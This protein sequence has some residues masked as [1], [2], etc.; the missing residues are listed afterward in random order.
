VLEL[1]IP[2]PPEQQPRRVKISAGGHAAVDAG[3]GS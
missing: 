2:H 1:R 3:T